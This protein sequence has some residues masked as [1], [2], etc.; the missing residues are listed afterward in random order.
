[1]TLSLLQQPALQEWIKSGSFSFRGSCSIPLGKEFCELHNHPYFEIVLHSHT[2]GV[3]HLEGGNSLEFAA[4]AFVLHPPVIAHSQLTLHPGSDLCILVEGPP[5]PPPQLQQLLLISGHNA[6]WLRADVAALLE[7]SRSGG[8]AG[9]EAWHHRVAALFLQLLEQ[10]QAPAL[11][12][13]LQGGAALAQAAEGRILRDYAI[14]TGVDQL[15]RELGVSSSYLRHAYRARFGTGLKRRMMQ[16]RLEHAR[17]LLVGSTLP[18]K[19]IAR[20]CGFQND[21]YFATSFKAE[22]GC[23]ASAYRAGGGVVPGRQS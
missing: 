21:R 4:G 12:E 23:P 15:A 17:D 2:S 1:M 13:A 6:P 3:V 9:K 8:A 5:H 22:V 14:L 16:V 19:T 10:V 20:A 18:I 7:G 11:P